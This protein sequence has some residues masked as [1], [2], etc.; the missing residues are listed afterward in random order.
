[1]RLSFRFLVPLVLALLA[2]A[3]L[4]TPFVDGLLRQWHTRDLD[5]RA[6]LVASSLQDSLRES[7]S[8]PE[9]GRITARLTDLIRDERLYAIAVCDPEGNRIAASAGFPAAVRCERAADPDRSRVITTP[10]GPLHVATR[11]IVHEGQGVGSLVVIHDMSF[12]ERRSEATKRYLFYLIAAI[13]IIVSLI[14]ITIAEVSLRGV[15]R[16]VRNMLRHRETDAPALPPTPELAPV[17]RDLRTLIQ[18]L[19]TARGLR[20]AMNI[21]WSPESLRNILRQDL[22]GEEVIILSN[23]EP[24]IHDKRDGKVVVRRPASGLVT[25]LEPV[26]RACSGTWIAHGGG[27]ADRETVDRH[28][29]VAVPPD[30]P[31]YNLRRI[32]LTAKQEKGYYYGFS[33]SGLWP[34]C[35]IAHVRPSFHS[36]DYEHYE[37]VNKKFADAVLAEAKSRDPIVLVQDYHFALVPRLVRERLPEATIIT[38]WHI[39]WPNPETFGIC[40]WRKDILEGL[41]GSTILGFHTQSHC[42]N[43]L[44]CVDRYLEARVDRETFTV[45]LKG[46]QT[47]VRRYPISIDWPLKSASMDKSIAECRKAVRD[48][49]NLPENV[50]LGVGVDRLDY[51]KGIIERMQAVARL[52]ELKPE[53]IGRF[54]FVQI[55]APS[56]GDIPEYKRFDEDVRNLAK[57]IN[58]RFARDGWRPII[59]LVEHHEPEHVY[60]YYRGS[61]LAVVSSLHDGMNL[62]AKEFIA[63]RDDERG[64]LILSQFTGAARELPES[65]IVNPYDIDQCAMAMHSALT[66]PE[67]DQRARMRS[68][69]GLVSEFNVYRWAGRMLL[70]AAST[71]MRERVLRQSAA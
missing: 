4:A 42:N 2:V 18:D 49:N 38:F 7:I 35:H 47:A 22:H 16:S 17:A 19:E 61:E 27:S 60:E 39:P 24:Y 23:R 56:R 59:L 58:E 30:K 26:M 62:V 57:G 69:R 55:A 1:V 41:L 34:L 14:T 44:D 66:M 28:D 9:D 25:A 29:H 31:S 51:T 12:A 33:N 65:L 40:P 45:T 63:A 3:Y 43:F 67:S 46:K 53:W 37:A 15:L 54:T 21:N 36:S 11:D 64:V 20:D 5:M 48:R 70:D 32:W 71:R 52:M 8:T 10:Q 13:A 6:T 68:M 50:L